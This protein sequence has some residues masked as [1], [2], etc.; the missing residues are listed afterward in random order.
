MVAEGAS[1]N[2]RDRYG[3]GALHFTIDH[4][5]TECLK[6]LLAG[7]ADINVPDSLART[8]LWMAASQD[9]HLKVSQYNY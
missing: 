9:G 1:L 6:V 8:P 5:S 2:K 7:G 4:E 3:K